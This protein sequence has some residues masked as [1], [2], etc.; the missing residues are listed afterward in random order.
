MYLYFLDTPRTLVVVIYYRY[1]SYWF[2]FLLLRNE[3]LND[4]YRCHV[5]L[6]A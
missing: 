6:S 5:C 2:L 3:E 4:Y 1:E